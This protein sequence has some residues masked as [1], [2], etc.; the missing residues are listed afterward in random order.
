[1]SSSIVKLAVLVAVTPE[2]NDPNI[3]Q[4][5]IPHHTDIPG[6]LTAY[7]SITFVSSEA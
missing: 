2:K 7:F 4:E 5:D 1:M 6:N 3:H